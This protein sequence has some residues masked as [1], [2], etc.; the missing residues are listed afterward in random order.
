MDIAMKQGSLNALGFASGGKSWWA[1][2]SAK[3]PPMNDAEAKQSYE[4][5]QQSFGDAFDLLDADNSGAIDKDELMAVIKSLGPSPVETHGFLHAPVPALRSPCRLRLPSVTPWRHQR[6][7]PCLRDSHAALRCSDARVKSP[8][9]QT[10]RAARLSVL[11]AHSTALPVAALSQASASRKGSMRNSPRCSAQ[12][13]Q[14]R[15]ASSSA[16]SS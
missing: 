1:T 16:T 3:E 8:L 13:T 14:T 7:H 9:I 5:N 10:L 4:E 12:R 2:H 11:K 6:P 15:T